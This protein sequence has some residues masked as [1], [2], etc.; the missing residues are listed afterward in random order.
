MPVSPEDGCGGA[1]AAGGMGGVGQQPDAATSAP[2]PLPPPGPPP[3]TGPAGTGGN[4]AEDVRIGEQAPVDL[5]LLVDK[6]GSMIGPK[7][8]M[9]TA[10]L[11]GFVRDPKSAGLG[12][13]LTFFPL[14]GS[15]SRCTNDVD[16]GLYASP[17]IHSCLD[18][19]GCVGP[20]G[21]TE[22]PPL[23]GLAFDPPCP[24]G[25]TCAPVGTCSL[26]YLDC[27]DIG[28]PCPGGP[29][30]DVC[31]GS[32]NYC[33]TNYNQAASCMPGDY[34]KVDAPIAQLP[35]G[36]PA[37]VA[38]IARNVPFGGTPTLLAVQGALSQLRQQEAR[39]PGH[40]PI[41]ILATDG[42]PTGCMNN[43]DSEPIGP[44]TA[45]L[46]AART[47]APSITTYVIG[48]FEA[49]D[50]PAGPM[51]V[52]ELAVA[53]G[54]GSAFVLAPTVDLTQ[55]L[56]EALN[57]IRGQALPCEFAIPRPATGTIDYGKVNVRFNGKSSQD[58]IPFVGSAARC[59]PMRGG[60]Y[61]D[62]DPVVT[63]PQR[64]LVCDATCAQFK[65]EASGS[66]QIAFG[67]K[68]RVIE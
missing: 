30:G 13:G 44:I 11:T 54:S 22:P 1:P 17:E 3:P 46:T 10:A 14:F 66:V 68:T 58:D 57:Q 53:G 12:V 65:A 18:R 20:R 61:Y 6:S 59:D 38:A 5:L 62:V 67:C 34:D 25:T 48:V 28:K 24:P 8:E 41:L 52:N 37:V 31:T 15:G 29:A 50:G 33:R 32:G 9:V 43:A 16:C 35:A 49:K 64:I 55:K 39:H 4:C 42:L 51:T 36:A 47:G 56:T 45:A 40:R 7:W 27:L 63:T 2:T 60:W 26:S 19:R 23:C 21:T